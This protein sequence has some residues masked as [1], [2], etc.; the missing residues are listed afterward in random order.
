MRRRWRDG[1]GR[2][3]GKKTKTPTTNNRRQRPAF[4]EPRGQRS[5]ND[6]PEHQ[7]DERRQHER[8]VGQPLDQRDGRI[9]AVRT[10]EGLDEELGEIE[11]GEQDA[12]KEDCPEYGASSQ[13]DPQSSADLAEDCGAGDVRCRLFTSCRW[14]CR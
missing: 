10:D 4:P 11:R 9:H 8:G 13:G 6:G 5:G 3:R 1:Q 7:A 12:S 14:S 2:A